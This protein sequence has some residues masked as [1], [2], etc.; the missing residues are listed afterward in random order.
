MNQHLFDDDSFISLINDENDEETQLSSVYSRYEEYSLYQGLNRTNTSSDYLNWAKL[1]FRADTRKVDVKRKYQGI[2]EF[3][4]DTSSLLIAFY[5]ILLIIF[6]FINT[7]YAELSISKKIFF[8]KELGDNNLNLQKNSKKINKLLLQTNKDSFQYQNFH[9]QIY[10]NNKR[11]ISPNSNVFSDISN[12]I[13]KYSRRNSSRKSGSIIELL[14]I[15]KF[16]VRSNSNEQNIDK[17]KNQKL[18]TDNISYS[19]NLNIQK[20]NKKFNNIKKS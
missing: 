2:M 15:N 18:Q 7:F 13:K 10:N 8:Y 14:S 9:S 16:D 11:T 1:F 4:A 5:Q 19:K 20:S 12:N 17:L 3:Y 6:N